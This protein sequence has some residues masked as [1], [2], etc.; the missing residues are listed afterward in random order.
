MRHQ[1]RQQAA[2]LLNLISANLGETP[3]VG[4]NYNG[5]KPDLSSGTATN[6]EELKRLADGIARAAQDLS[7]VCEKEI[8]R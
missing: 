7:S 4:T 8:G 1:A 3:S 2:L 5:R 6:V